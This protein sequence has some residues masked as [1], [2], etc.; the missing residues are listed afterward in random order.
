[1]ETIREEVRDGD[2]IAG[3][4]GILAQA[5]RHELPVEVGADGQANR[6]PDRF[7]RTAEVRKTRKTH[8]QIARHIGGFRGKRREPRTEASAAQEVFFGR[9]IRLLRIDEADDHDH[10]EIKEHCEQYPKV[11]S[12]HTSPFSFLSSVMFVASGHLRRLFLGK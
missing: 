9:A 6:R 3:N 11:T 10:D 8:E 4:L 1:M 12:N 7:V 2:G 5:F